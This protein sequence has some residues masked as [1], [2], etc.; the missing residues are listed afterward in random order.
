MH[1]VGAMITYESV[2][3]GEG[4]GTLGW[5]KGGHGAALGDYKRGEVREEMRGVG[6]C[7]EDDVPSA[8]AA[9]SCV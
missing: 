4:L 2:R 9:T 3:V 7:R 8:N 1:R 6:V 5:N